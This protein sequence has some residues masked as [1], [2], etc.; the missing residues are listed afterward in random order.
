MDQPLARVN[1]NHHLDFRM[2]SQVLDRLLNPFR[3]A[4]GKYIAAKC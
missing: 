2:C 3:H 4:C 1:P